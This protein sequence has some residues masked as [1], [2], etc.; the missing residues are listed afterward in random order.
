MSANGGSAV[1]IYAP[2]T[3]SSGSSYSHLNYATFNDTENELMVYAISS[4]EAIHDPGPV[5]RGLLR[6]LGWNMK[7]SG[8]FYYPF[9]TSS[10]KGWT[11]RPGGPWAVASGTLYTNGATDQWSTISH[12][13]TYSDFE[14]S[15]RIKRVDA[16]DGK[17]LTNGMLIRGNPTTYTSN[18]AWQNAYLF[19]YTDAGKFAVYRLEAGRSYALKSWTVSSAI[20]TSDWNELKVVAVGSSLRFLI[21]GKRV[22]S[23]T[24]GAFSSG[25]VGL[26]MYRNNVVERMS[27]DWTRLEVLSPGSSATG[28]TDEPTLPFEPEIS[29]DG[30]ESGHRG[31]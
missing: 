3:W 2:G 19:G 12:A 1:R 8:G 29:P 10:L 13:T 20:K 27:V 14:Y 18:N 31:E 22:W 26:A 4:G 15:A 30:E 7:G 23:G 5:A 28:D 6:D 9:T 21:N 25:K 24:D 16:G 11:Q 17:Y